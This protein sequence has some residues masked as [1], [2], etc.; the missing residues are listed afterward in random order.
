MIWAGRQGGGLL[1]FDPENFYAVRD[2]RYNNV[3][4]KLPHMTV[5]SL[6]KD[7]END[8]WMGSWD[9][10]VYRYAKGRGESVD[11]F[12]LDADDGQAF[13]Q[14][15]MNRIWSGGKY[16]GLY[17]FDPL[18][19][20]YF[21]YVNDPSKDGMLAD[22]QVNYIYID[23]SGLSCWYEQGHQRTRSCSATILPGVSSTA[24]SQTKDHYL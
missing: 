18:S 24:G 10:V 15:A 1:K 4:L 20:K 8:M 11:K 23:H 6:F 19:R 3:Y 17:L 21:H 5:T 13:A 14:D 7:S 2:E 22:N 16:N 9:K 12:P